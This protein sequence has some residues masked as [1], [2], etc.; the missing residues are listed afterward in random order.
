M[1]L[2]SADPRVERVEHLAYLPIYLFCFPSSFPLFFPFFPNLH[3]IY[4]YR[5]TQLFKYIPEIRAR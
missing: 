3:N 4:I 5:D 1:Y 2:K